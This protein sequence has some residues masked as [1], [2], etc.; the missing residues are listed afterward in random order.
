MVA[1]R[2][3]PVYDSLL[4]FILEHAS[5]QDVL[6]FQASPEEQQRADELTE[7]NK[8]GRL[9]PDEA[10]ELERMLEADLLVAALKA[11]A[12]AAMKSK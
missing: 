3:A 1:V 6:R 11:R 2:L 7:K 4:D 12:L 9:T 8:L 10:E 5:P